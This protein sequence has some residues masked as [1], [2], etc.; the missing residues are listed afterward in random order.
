V[1]LALLLVF[2]AQAVFGQQFSVPRQSPAATALSS[3][4]TGSSDAAGQMLREGRLLEMEGRW[5][6]ALTHYED[7]MRRFPEHDAL[8]RRFEFTRLHY[9]LGRRYADRSFRSAVESLGFEAALDVY[10]E[11]LLKI[12]AHYVESPNFKELLERGS[13][14]LE[15]AL[16]ER[17]F[18]DHLA[19]EVKAEAV[20]RFRGELRRSLGLR[21]VRTRADARE[22]V[23]LAAEMAW[24]RLGIPRAATVLEYT[25]GATSSLDAYSAYL[26]PDQLSEV[27]S[28]IEGNFV[29][30][31]I[32][33][34]AEDGALLIVRVIPGSP[35]E[36]SGIR[37][38][39]RIVAVDGQST[40]ELSTD[41]AAN[42]L[43]GEAGSL[44]DLKLRTPDGNNRSVRVRRER[45]EVPSIEGA[46][47]V[48]ADHGIAYAKLTCFQKTTCRDL[49]AALWDLHRSGM[50][51]LVLDLRG[52]PG[53]LLITSVEVVDRFVE[54]GLIVSTRGRSLQEDF[55]YSAHVAGTWKVP[56]VVLIDRDSASAAEIFAGAIR[57]HRRGTII[58]VRSYGKGS[59]QGIFPLSNTDAGI[60]LTTAK[61]YS[62]SGRPFS[63]LG[64]EPDM[65]VHRADKPVSGGPALTLQDSDQA[66]SLAVEVARQSMAQR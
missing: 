66:L 10:E 56:L 58:G 3:S 34:R 22:A 8:Q 45:V 7:A 18:L 59:V 12:Q 51:S 4:S 16:T 48:D 65:V 31:G 25:C 30:L 64:V 49:D 2:A 32:E 60:R 17:V 23:A 24:N 27:Y 6:E 61:F 19:P 38:N 39:D 29:G 63:R 62:P 11:V 26:T 15:V 44:V 52:N 40:R 33:L 42:L 54:R 46:R 9:D 20:D 55:T 35:A 36:H 47:I 57:D 13:N 37:K 50:K 43:Q 14:C 28:Q 21:V 5:G 1:K 41:Q 53:G